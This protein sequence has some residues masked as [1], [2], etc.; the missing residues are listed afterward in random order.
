ME[1]IFQHLHGTGVARECRRCGSVR[2]EISMSQKGVHIEPAEGKLGVLLVGLGAVSTTLIA[3]VEAVKQ[4]LG[5]P[6]GSLTQLGTVRLGKRTENRVPRIQDFVPLAKLEDLVFGSWDIFP[7]DAYEAACEANVLERN[8]LDQL[9]PELEPV[10]PMRGVF[11]SRYVKRL[12]GTY[13]KEGNK[14]E[15]AR[16]LIAEIEDF[17]RQRGV[18]RSVMVWCGSTEGHMCAPEGHGGPAR[19][20]G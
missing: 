4:G 19:F 11:D 6:I 15:L 13:T 10:Q 2:E 12:H 3:G 20:G 14:W 8:L 16:Q 5:K 9:R 18:D 1:R 17:Q 7:D